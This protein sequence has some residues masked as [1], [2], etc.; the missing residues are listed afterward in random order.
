MRVGQRGGSGSD[1]G[2]AGRRR[3]R[4]LRAGG[5]HTAPCFRPSLLEELD[6]LKQFYES[7]YLIQH[8]RNEGSMNR[9]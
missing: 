9:G 2:S 5:G 1:S 6:G 4:G 7:H 8:L 3:G